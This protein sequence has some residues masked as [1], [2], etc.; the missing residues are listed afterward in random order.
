MLSASKTGLARLCLY[1]FRPDVPQDVRTTSD[2]AES[3][4]TVHGAIEHFQKTGKV[5]YALSSEG[6]EAMVHHAV[7][8]LRG[9]V[10]NLES[11]VPYAWDPMTD[12]GSRLDGAIDDLGIGGHRLYDDPEW[13]REIRGICGL[14]ASA[15]P[16]TIDLLEIGDGTATIYDWCTGT[17]DKRAQLQTNALAVART[18]GITSVRLVTLRLTPASLTE[19]DHGTLDEADL[20]AL[21]EEFAALVAAIPD[22]EPRPGMHCRELYCSAKGACPTTQ[23]AL[24]QVI[25]ADQLARFR[26]TDKIESMAHAS[27]VLPM[28]KVLDK[29]LEQVKEALEAYHDAHGP[30]PTSDGKEWRRCVRQMSRWNKDKAVAKLHFLGASEADLEDLTKVV[31]EQYFAERKAKGA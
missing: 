25:P 4:T 14:S 7:A 31:P 24:A 16:M 19:E 26:F 3:G 11:E 1:S 27:A 21:A 10:G 18:H 22:A 28:L 2:A 13:W 30:I 9:H 29:Y 6:E 5:E 12:D 8:W 15:I 20:A 17:T 23:R